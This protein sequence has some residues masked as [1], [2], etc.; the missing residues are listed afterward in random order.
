MV[1][2]T[3]HTDL[4]NYKTFESICNSVHLKKF[5]ICNTIIE[6]YNH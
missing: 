3:D 1:Q 4:Q 5:V 2:I 6:I